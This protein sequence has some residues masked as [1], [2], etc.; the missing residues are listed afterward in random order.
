[1]THCCFFDTEPLMEHLHKL[2]V[3]RI[4]THWETI[5]LNLQFNSADINAIVQR[6][7]DIA[8]N[9]CYEMLTEWLNKSTEST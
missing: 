8:F 1:M 2:I 6:E 7:N 5:A 3:P 9:C 4:A